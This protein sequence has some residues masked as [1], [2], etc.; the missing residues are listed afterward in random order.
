MRC[1]REGVDLSVQPAAAEC[2]TLYP[3]GPVAGLVATGPEALQ[4]PAQVRLP[5]GLE[6]RERPES[7]PVPP[8]EVPDHVGGPER[9]LEGDLS[10]RRRGPGYPE[11]LSSRPLRPRREHRPEHRDDGPEARVRIGQPLR[12]ADLE[13]DRKPFLGRARLRLLDQVGSDVDAGDERPARAAGRAGLPVPQAT[14]S[15]CS[16]AEA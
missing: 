5:S 8:L 13:G 16:R 14:S 2:L 11:Q 9:E 15:T 7:R 12:V 4:L 6:C 1:A 3:R 10:P